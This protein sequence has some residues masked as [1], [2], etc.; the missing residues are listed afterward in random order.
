MED[1]PITT[2]VL[3]GCTSDDTRL[4]MIDWRSERMKEALISE[5]ITDIRQFLSFSGMS[6]ILPGLCTLVTT[7]TTATATGEM[8]LFTEHNAKIDPAMHALALR[9]LPNN[10]R[11]GLPVLKYSSGAPTSTLQPSSALD[12]N[13]VAQDSLHNFGQ[14]KNMLVRP[15]SS[16]NEEETKLRT[17]L[18]AAYRLFHLFGWTDLVY[19]HLTVRLPG[20]E[21]FLINPFGRSFDEVLFSYAC[22]IRIS[23][24]VSQR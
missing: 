18:A 12:G 21:H 2:F 22:K 20:T 17:K 8:Q 16:W 23:Y 1:L 13:P 10:D 24:C 3:Q 11:H 6:F 15:R 7:T 19:N 14:N 5:V 9:V 4:F